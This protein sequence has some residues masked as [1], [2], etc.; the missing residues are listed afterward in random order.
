[1]GGTSSRN[2][3]GAYEMSGMGS[4]S[5]II[6]LNGGISTM[7]LS[8]A[9]IDD[10]MV[11]LEIGGSEKSGMYLMLALMTSNGQNR[12]YRLGRII[13]IR[14]SNGQVMSFGAMFTDQSAERRGLVNAIVLSPPGTLRFNRI[15]S[16]ISFVGSGCNF[17]CALR[18]VVGLRSSVQAMT[19]EQFE[20]LLSRETRR[21][22][23]EP[24]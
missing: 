19:S 9:A 3:D 10:S 5:D 8:G 1:M 14:Q 17:S 22:E 21:Q 20:Q 7:R 15:P 16:P 23:D 12:T 24:Q 6:L 2:F 18:R 4:G 13:D 11:F